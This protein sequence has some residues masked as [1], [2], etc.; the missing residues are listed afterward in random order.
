MNAHMLGRLNLQAA[1]AMRAV[2]YPNIVA[3]QRQMPV[4]P[5]L[6]IQPN[7]PELVVRGRQAQRDQPLVLKLQFGFLAKPVRFHLAGGQHDMGVVVANVGRRYPACGWQNPPPR[8]NDPRGPGRTRGL[9]LIAARRQ[10]VGKRNLD[11][12]RHPRVFALLRRLGHVPQGRAVF[13]PIGFRA[14]GM[15]ISA[16]STPPLRVKS[17][18]R[19]S[20]SLVSFWRRDKPPTPRRCVRRCG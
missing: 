5:L 20:R 6:P 16:C 4:G 18:V 13:G 17:W 1:I 3:R 8:R 11:L 12:A 19:P 9:A 7:I 15:T 2:V 14:F 10:F